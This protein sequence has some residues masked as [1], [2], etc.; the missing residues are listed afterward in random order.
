V[1]KRGKQQFATLLLETEKAMDM[2]RELE[3]ELLQW[4]DRNDRAK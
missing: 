4:E 3:F 1:Q 2:K